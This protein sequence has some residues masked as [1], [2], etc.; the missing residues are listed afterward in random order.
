MKQ[1]RDSGANPGVDE[2]RRKLIKAAAVAGGAVV[3]VGALPGEWKKPLA[4]VGGL[5][6]HAQTSDARIVLSNLALFSMAGGDMRTV[7][8]MGQVPCE[9]SVE[10]EDPLCQVGTGVTASGWIT[11]CGVTAPFST[12]LGDLGATIVEGNSCAGVLHFNFSA[13]ICSDESTDG[14]LQLTLSI[15]ARVSN[16]IS[17]AF[18]LPV[19]PGEPA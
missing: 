1:H 11:M 19:W 3:A 18:T 15:G 6:A 12:T 9:W 16:E 10:F 4:T 17:V 8:I 13:P 2:G 14:T 7:A 5:P